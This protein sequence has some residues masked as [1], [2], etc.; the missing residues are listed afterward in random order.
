MG[1]S[2]LLGKPVKHAGDGRGVAWQQDGILVV[3]HPGEIVIFLVTSCHGNWLQ[4]P[5]SY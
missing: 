5:M 3:S 1:T 4:L 2:G